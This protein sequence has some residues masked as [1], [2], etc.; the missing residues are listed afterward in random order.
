ML[1]IGPLTL[2][3]L[4]AILVLFVSFYEKIFISLSIIRYMKHK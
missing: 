4:F 2:I 1:Q 3:F